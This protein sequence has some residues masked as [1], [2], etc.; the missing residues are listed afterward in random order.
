MM[1]RA[2]EVER[3]EEELEE[4]GVVAVGVEV[5]VVGES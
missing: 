1:I 4:S 2:V 5:G 3:V